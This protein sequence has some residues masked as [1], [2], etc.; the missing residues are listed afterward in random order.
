M[1]SVIVC[2]I[3]PPEWTVHERNVA[4]TVNA[5]SEYIRIDNRNTGKGICPAYNSGVERASGDCLVFMHEDA[6]FM[7]KGWGKALERKFSDDPSLGLVG[8]AGTQYLCK[9]KMSWTF[10]GRP[11]LRGRVVHELDGGREFFMTAFS[12]DRTDANV[13]AVDG[14]FFAVRRTLFT[15]V[16]FDEATF[17]RFHFYDLDLCMQVRRTHRLIATWDILIKHCSAGKP[18]ETWREY[19]RRFLEKYRLELP[20]NCSDTEPDFSVQREKGMNIDLKGR[21]NQDIIC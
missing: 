18:D 15:A 14:L 1:I 16:R 5:E 7:E 8:V 6:F 3:K 10:A 20:A 2:S 11:F 4:R 21:A 13:V 9:D 17:D 12:T 19:G